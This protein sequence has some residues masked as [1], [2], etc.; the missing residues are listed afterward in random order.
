MAV[1]RTALVLRS[2]QIGEKTLDV[3]DPL[4]NSAIPYHFRLFV[5]Q[6]LFCASNNDA[7]KSITKLCTKQANQQ[8]FIAP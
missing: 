4:Y 6:M 1:E 5:V 2:W 8:G 3:V 7:I